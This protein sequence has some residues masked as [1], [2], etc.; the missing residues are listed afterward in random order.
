MTTQ[1]RYGAAG[2]KSGGCFGK[3]S[4]EGMAAAIK[5]I[6]ATAKSLIAL[7]AVGGWIAVVVILVIC[8]RAFVSSAF[9]I[10]YSNEFDNTPVM[11]EVVNRLNG[12]FAETNE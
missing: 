2:G 8:L 1:R 3:D 7:I 11:T 9:G 12:E 10:F 6:I 5:A 4:S